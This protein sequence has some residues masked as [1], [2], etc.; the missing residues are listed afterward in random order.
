MK[1]SQNLKKCIIKPWVQIF[2][3]SYRPFPDYL[4]WIRHVKFLEIKKWA[5]IYGITPLYWHAPPLPQEWKTSFGPFKIAEN[6]LNIFT[7]FFHSYHF[8]IVLSACRIQHKM[9]LWKAYF[10]EFLWTYDE[11]YSNSHLKKTQY[12]AKCVLMSTSARNIFFVEYWLLEHISMRKRG[13]KVEILHFTHGMSLF[14]SKPFRSFSH[15][16]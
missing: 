13:E 11:F 16:G 1:S 5:K 12:V 8:F 7:Q 3:H 4:V 14:S 2:V 6:V 10:E 15:R 9:L